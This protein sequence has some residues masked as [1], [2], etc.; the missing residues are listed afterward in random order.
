MKKF[1]PLLFIV[2]F[3]TLVF[4]LNIYLAKRFAWYFGSEGVRPYYVVFATITVF[5]IGSIVAFTNAS[6][7]FSNIMFSIAV[8][9]MG[10][11]LYLILA[12]VGLHALQFI[13][14]IQPLYFGILAMMIAS[15]VSVYGLLNARNLQVKELEVAVK[16][17]KKEL[18]I[19]HLTDIHIGHWHGKKYLKKIVEQTN[20]HQVDYVFITGDLFDGR[21]RLNDEN[22]EPLKQLDAPVFFVEGNHDG[23][24]GVE[25]IKSRLRKMGVTVL[26]NQVLQ[27]E[28]FQLIGLN[29]MLADDSSYNMHAASERQT[30]QGVLNGLE[31]NNSTPSILLHHSPDGV[32]YAN[33]KGIDLYLAGH[34]HAGQLFPITLLNEWIFTYNKGL[35]DFQGT[36]IYV[37]H[38]AGT[39]GPPMR[40]GSRSEIT[41]IT[42]HNNQHLL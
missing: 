22:L 28:D 39:F 2:A 40:V 25:D 24:S 12:V 16:G 19:M 37:S 4:V 17:M 26:E 9:G 20:Q 30:I 11:L 18:K 23:Y 31:I 10:Y 32:K 34:T 36:K 5:V 6:G 13:I 3:L 41:L 38:G 21:I 27:L 42:I 15:T 14:K 7:A 29:H 35:H 33:E 1:I 8:V